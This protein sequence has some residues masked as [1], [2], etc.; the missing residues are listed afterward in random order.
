VGLKFHVPTRSASMFFGLLGYVG[1]PTAKN[2]NVP[3]EPFSADAKGWALM[4][5]WTVDLKNASS[6]FPLKISLNAGYR[7]HDWADRFF[8]DSKDQLL[9]GFGFKIPIRSSLLYSEVSGEFFTN[10]QE[11]VAFNQ[12]SYRFT[13]GFRFLGPGNL[14][15]DLG[16]DFEL[17]RYVP[18]AEEVASKPYLKDYAD[19]KIIFGISYRAT[20]FKYVSAEEK[21]VKKRQQNDEEKMDSIKEKRG[22]VLKEL[23]EI[24]RKLEKEKGKKPE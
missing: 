10:N 18:T 17:G 11:N 6:T 24:R 12:N 14:V 9:A 15:F 20:L 4:G 8:T 19:W 21:L 16:A 22:N 5:L 7:D 3:Y 23:E 1:F 2:H 13:Q